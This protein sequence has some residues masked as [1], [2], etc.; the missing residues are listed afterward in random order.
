VTKGRFWALFGSYLLLILMYVVAAIAGYVA[1]AAVVGVSLFNGTVDPN[2]MEGQIMSQLAAPT[3]WIPIA[4]IYAAIVVV[5]F[6]LVVALYG[7]N[8][9]AASLALAEGKIKVAE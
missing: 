7:V 4:I 5:A 2:A 1:M 3:V 9:R 8:A 6:V